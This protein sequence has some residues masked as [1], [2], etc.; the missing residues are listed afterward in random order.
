MGMFS[1]SQTQNSSSTNDSTSHGN[2]TDNPAYQQFLAG[3]GNVANSGISDISTPTNPYG[4]QAG[5][6]QAGVADNLNPA[7]GAAGSAAA[8]TTYNADSYRPYM[9]AYTND[10]TNAIRDQFG[11]TM[12]QA[13]ETIGGNLASQGALGNSNNV[14]ARANA[15]APIANAENTAIAQ[16]IQQGFNQANQNAQ[17]AG[18]FQLSGANSL[19]N[20][21]NANT[22]ANSALANIGQGLFGNQITAQEFPAQ[23]A[24]L[25]NQGWLSN[26]A[27]QG[28][29]SHSSGTGTSTTTSNP[30]LFSDIMGTIGMA[31]SIFSGLPTGGGMGGGGGRSG[32]ASGGVI[33][34][35]AD[36]GA[37]I[38]LD[39]VLLAHLIKG[40]PP[41]FKGFADGGDVQDQ[42]VMG[43][44]PW[45]A[46][47][48]EDAKA[49]RGAWD[50]K[51]KTNDASAFLTVPGHAARIGA[52]LTMIPQAFRAKDA[53]AKA[54]D[55]PSIPTLTNAGVQSAI[56][57]LPFNP[58]GTAKAIL[59]TMGTGYAAAT[60]KELGL[61]EAFKPSSAHAEERF[62]PV[63]AALSDS[64]IKDYERMKR[65]AVNGDKDVLPILSGYQTRIQKAQDDF[66]DR[67]K[68][69]ATIKATAGTAEAKAKADAEREASIRADAAR[70]DILGKAS[71]SYDSQMAKDRRFSDTEWGKVYDETGGTA[72]FIVSAAGGALSGLA[73]H[74]L[75]AAA[76]EGA[77]LG[78]AGTSL[79]FLTDYVNSPS[80]NPKRQAMVAYN[81]IAPPDD[82]RRIRY[83]ELMK[84]DQ[85][86]PIANPVPELAMQK[87]FDPR[88]IGLSLAEGAG[89]GMTGW[90]IPK[91]FSYA[92][93][94]AA[95]AAVSTVRGAG[96]LTKD[97]VLGTA[98]TLGEIPGATAES[99]HKGMGRAAT[100]KEASAELQRNASDATRSAVRA[101]SDALAEREAFAE[102]LRKKGAQTGAAD[103]SVSPLPVRPSA[104]DR[105]SGQASG[106]PSVGVT[107]TAI[108]LPNRQE[109]MDEL[110]AIRQGVEAQ[111]VKA[112][113]G[114][115]DPV[116]REAIP[117]PKS[118]SYV[119]K[120]K[121]MGGP[122]VASEVDAGREIPATQMLMK[123][124]D[125]A[126]LARPS[127]K[128]AHERLTN[129][130]TLLGKIR[131][132]NPGI[133]DADAAKMLGS[134]MANPK[135]LPSDWGLPKEF[136]LPA[137]AAPVIGS[138]MSDKQE[139][140]ADGGMVSPETHAL[141]EDHS[142][143][144]RGVGSKVRGPDGAFAP[145][146]V[147]QRK[148]G[149][150]APNPVRYKRSYATGG[151]VV[152]PVVG[153]TGGRTDAK[154]VS[155]PANAYVIPADVVSAVPGAEGNT[156]AGMEKLKQI[157]GSGN[158]GYAAGGTAHKPVPILISD[159]EYVVPPEVV[160]MHGG[161]DV[162]QGHRILDAFV[163]K[164]RSANIKKLKA[165]P[166][167]AR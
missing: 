90:T 115:P 62:D 108:A 100:A 126:G 55:D 133:S 131:S 125:D 148:N 58:T 155:V 111:K 160:A 105:N 8:G 84:N 59:G 122:Y 12:K 85:D 40:M 77:L 152:G 52:E 17:A 120:Y 18:N 36:G 94:A 72:P 43:V 116:K 29:T 22:G 69:E 157:F 127:T 118:P 151:V 44:Q 103:Q 113:A 162:K 76:G 106:A 137:V 86:Y 117:A 92:A 146:G 163:K 81:E 99:F 124:F 68:S 6:A 48:I 112:A 26:N 138:A 39:P 97:A 74:S 9:S 153:T 158:V 134:M 164:L 88:R 45:L 140:R 67:L 4:N 147:A 119:G 65:R 165:L 87:L 114:V 25:Y 156:L 21:A 71:A 3:Y 41:A 93:P 49:D 149:G 96:N 31:T 123:Q 107:D 15:L 128:T 32:S 60:A 16:N 53:I 145:M 89:A 166:A 101:R 64:E 10:V 20:L 51:N 83:E 5:A 121:K 143:D 35:Y 132:F 98:R 1:S 2:L 61:P 54:Y 70:K 46:K 7:Y 82:P 136:I 135:K 42:P 38:D 144:H 167:P 37:V 141:P 27:I 154:P 150:A 14:V 110:A 33:Q 109:I 19:G 13:N 57:G 75:P 102:S 50:T 28:Q 73:K 56:M 23:L 11:T 139:V 47:Q 66:N 80:L 129:A 24:N 30:S 104:S 161:G 78:L 95:D 91:A 130:E 159:G 142:W 34:P 63:R 79:P